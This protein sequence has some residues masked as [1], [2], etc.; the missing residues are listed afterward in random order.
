MN[1]ATAG[2]GA[3][4]DPCG[5]HAGGHGQRLARL[6]AGHDAKRDLPLRGQAEQDGGVLGGRRGL[7]RRGPIEGP[8]QTELHVGDQRLGSGVGDRDHGDDLVGHLAGQVRHV[9]ARGARGERQQR[10]QP[11]GTSR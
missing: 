8:V 9:E 11:G 3:G 1:P 2:H 4:G 6:V 10:E 5:E 7:L